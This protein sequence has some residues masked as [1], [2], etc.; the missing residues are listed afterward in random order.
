[1]RRVPA[2]TVTW[3]RV[4]V[5][6]EDPVHG[7]H[8]EHHLAVVERQVAVVASGASGADG[9]RVLPAV[10]EN[11]A[12]LVNRGRAGYQGPGP[13]RADQGV[14]LLP[15]QEGRHVGFFF[16]HRCFSRWLVAGGMIHGLNGRTAGRQDGK[17]ARRQDGKTPTQ[18]RNGRYPCRKAVN[19]RMAQ[20]PCGTMNEGITTNAQPL[21]KECNE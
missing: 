14:D 1:M 7:A 18:K 13:D 19:S 3:L 20:S 12:A 2:S 4:L 10:G 11:L 15:F 6:V 17:T 16:W 5:E 8:V 9:Q 21:H